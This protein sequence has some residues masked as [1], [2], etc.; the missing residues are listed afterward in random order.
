MR[1]GA[2]VRSSARLT[3]TFSSFTKRKSERE[4]GG[5]KVEQEATN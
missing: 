3:A 2:E 5:A 4:K 1:V